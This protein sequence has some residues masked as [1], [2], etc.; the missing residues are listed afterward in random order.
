[1]ENIVLKIDQHGI[2]L[3]EFNRP[4]ELNAL[5]P[6]LILEVSASLRDLADNDEVRALVITGRGRGFCAGADLKVFE[7][8]AN[9]PAHPLGDFIA[10]RMQREFNPM[11]ELLHAFP[12]P[13]VTAL[14][15][16]AAGG[17]AGIALCADIVIASEKAAL[18]VVQA[19][20]LGI[21]ADLGVNWLLPRIAG[22]GRA[23]GICLL[24]DTIPAATLHEWGLV[25][26]C[27]SPDT[28]IDTATA[29]AL[30]LA[31][32]PVETVLASRGLI[33]SANHRSF[34]QVL[35]DERLIQRDLTNAPAFV[36]SV[37]RFLNH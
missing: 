35:E 27:V 36:D 13:L 28:L 11:M 9:D 16:I 37:R 34:N 19:Q 12:R 30:R 18:K 10:D 17:G 22:R 24:G 7:A 32:V 1:M 3:L 5:N 2:A 21:V 29:Y 15:G 14:N 4:D 20:Q 31:Q 25:W 26:E 33:D 6:E 8:G 23:L